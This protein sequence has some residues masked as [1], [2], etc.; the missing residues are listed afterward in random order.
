M[1]RT[2]FYPGSFDPVTFG[3]LDIL[4]RALRLFDG[5]VI[6]IGVHHGKTPV[7]T[8]EVRAELL[9]AEMEHLGG[10]ACTKIVTFSGLVVDAAREHGACALLRGLRDVSD[11][12]YEIQ[13]AAMNAAMAPQI[14]TV[15][16][17]A[18][19]AVRP[20]AASLVRQIAAMGGDVSSFVPPA[21]AARLAEK[22][23]TSHV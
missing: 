6:G 2:A 19:P 5:L 15:F 14:D 23:K 18:S 13:M 7:F 16:L 8:A 1:T 11:F 20:I 12:D 3:H 17:A 10:S 21:V 4:S 9:R 22:Y